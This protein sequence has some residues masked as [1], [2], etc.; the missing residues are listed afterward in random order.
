MEWN[1]KNALNRDTERQ[2]LNKILADIRATYNEL[3]GQKSS[4][5]SVSLDAL[6]SAVE[7]NIE[8]G[9]SVTYDPQ[10]QTLDFVVNSFTIRLTG[11][12]T[13][14]G[15]VNALGSVTLV[16]E[17]DPSLIGVE[18]APV[19]NQIYWRK[20]A[21]WEA[22]PDSLF[23]FVDLKDEGVPVLYQD[24][25]TSRYDWV[26]RIFEVEDG[27]LTVENSTGEAGNFKFGL[28]DVVDSGTGSL[29]GIT[30]DSKG[31]ITGTTDATITGTTDEIDVA[32][33]DAASG[34]PTISLA[35]LADTGVGDPTIKLITR[36]SKGRVEGTEDASTD[37]LPEGTTNLYFT[38]ERVYAAAKAALVAGANVTITPDDGNET[39]T[40]TAS[41]G[42]SGG[43][44]ILVQDGASAPPVMLTNEIEDDFIY[45]D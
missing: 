20:N 43:G 13:G 14:Q 28:A 8:E 29:R 24:D 32:N 10:K 17:L 11:D 41:G 35:D 3:A 2:H 7:G 25:V 39:L 4:T 34:S 23:S 33:G 22:V 15:Q 36:D 1:V 5:G 16:T 44:E 38:D 21:E 19:D 31:R 40:I 30:V 45:S 27:E 12:V 18:E 26:V 42:G 37:N 9:I 6:A